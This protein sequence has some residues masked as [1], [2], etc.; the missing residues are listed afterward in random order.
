MAVSL[1]CGVTVISR[2]MCEYAF[3]RP[4]IARQLEQADE[5]VLKKGVLPPD[6]GGAAPTVM[7]TNEIIA[8]YKSSS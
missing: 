3:A 5:S 6:L 8:A 4:D 7:V 1:Y 2:M